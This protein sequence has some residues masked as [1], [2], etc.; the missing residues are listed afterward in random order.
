MVNALHLKKNKPK[1]LPK[2]ILILKK[3]KKKKKTPENP[4]RMKKT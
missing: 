4:R 2:K 3:Q 1:S